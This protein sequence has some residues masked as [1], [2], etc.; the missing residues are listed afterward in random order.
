MYMACLL[1]PA[2]SHSWLSYLDPQGA[3]RLFPGLSLY[4]SRKFM[5]HL[6]ALKVVVLLVVRHKL[7]VRE[8]PV[9]FNRKLR[10]LWGILMFYNFLSSL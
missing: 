9:A 3:V 5:R 1:E 8:K 2:G 6:K 7:I 4:D 10:E